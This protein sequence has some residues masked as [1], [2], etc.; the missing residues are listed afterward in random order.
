MNG[1]QVVLIVDDLIANIELLEAFLVPQ[2]YEIV[3]AESG[4]EALKKIDED[5]IDLVLLDVMM[6]G[7]DGFEVI[8]KIRQ[9][10]KNRQLPIILVTALRETEERV[11]GIEA[12]CDDFL[13]K[14]VDKLELLARVRSLLKVKAYNDLMD[15][16]RKDLEAEVA[17]KTKELAIA[18]EKIK[19]AS[20]ES[21]HKLSVAAEYRDED[22]DAHIRRVNR[23]TAAIARRMGMDEVTIEAILRAAPID[24]PIDEPV[25]SGANA[26]GKPKA[27]D[28]GIISIAETIALCRHER[29][30]GNGYPNGLQGKAIPLTGRIAAIAGAFDALISRRSY[31]NPL[32]AEKALELI[33]EGSGS[34]FDPEVV[35]VFFAIRDEI[36]ALKKQYDGYDERIFE[37]PE[38]KALLQQFKRHYH[39]LSP[40]YTIVF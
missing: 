19:A 2:G 23:Y 24:E 40:G 22:G 37:L 6:A 30:D 27:A 28:V 1:N 12:G 18:L 11:K 8:K 15:S 31:N 29:W 13:S 9:D 7:M 32:S 10:E 38:M 4:E 5:R 39:V 35:E 21:V 14:P 33:K 34:R 3:K 17:A 20:L 26:A 25:A 36:L 16:Y